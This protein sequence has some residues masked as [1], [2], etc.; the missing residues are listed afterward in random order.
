MLEN[1]RLTVSVRST[2]WTERG[3]KLLPDIHTSRITCARLRWEYRRPLNHQDNPL[4]VRSNTL[5]S[6]CVQTV[7]PLN[8]IAIKMT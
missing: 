3:T 7:N 8:L 5:L 6:D 2:C 1:N 4:R